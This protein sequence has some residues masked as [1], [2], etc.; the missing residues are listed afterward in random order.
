MSRIYFTD[1]TAEAE[2][3]G[4]E[5]AHMGLMIDNIWK[6]LITPWQDYGSA[7]SVLRRIVP[8]APPLTLPRPPIFGDFSH[9]SFWSGSGSRNGEFVLPS[10]EHVGF[11][12]ASLNTALELGRH[13]RLF[14][15]LHGGCEVHAFV[16]GQNRAWLADEIDA[17]LAVGICR[18]DQGWQDVVTFLRARTDEPVVTSYS[19]TEGFPDASLVDYEWEAFDK[20]PDDERWRLCLAALRD[21]KGGPE[22]RP[23]WDSWFGPGT[24]Q[25]WNAWNLIELAYG[26]GKNTEVLVPSA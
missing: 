19:I 16:E 17:G 22:M 24:T 7:P 4:S 21:G 10:G 12:E 11:F 13:L 9:E 15:W 1:R 20:L 26:L 3:R 2:L 18:T 25:A 8:S 5:R 23:D 14:A 6:A